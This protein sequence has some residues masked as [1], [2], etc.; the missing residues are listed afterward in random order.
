MLI[1]TFKFLNTIYN[2]S[3]EV[4]TPISATVTTSHGGHKL[5]PHPRSGSLLRTPLWWGGRVSRCCV[6]SSCCTLHPL[7]HAAV[8]KLLWGPPRP[9]GTADLLPL[10]SSA[11]R[12]VS[13]SP[14]KFSCFLYTA[15][16]AD[17]YCMKN[18][19]G[20]CWLLFDSADDCF[21]L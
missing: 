12:T 11:P 9:S 13:H 14:Y 16:Q 3:Q 15:L 4:L 19:F 8:R 18:L 20:S 21:P 7:T 5:T 6:N 1:H 10:S 2:S 17:C